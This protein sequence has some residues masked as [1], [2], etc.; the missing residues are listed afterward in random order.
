MPCTRKLSVKAA[1]KKKISSEKGLGLP[2]CVCRWRCLIQCQL[3][4]QQSR[5]LID[6]E[7]PHSHSPFSSLK[8][9]THWSR[10]SFSISCWN[11]WHRSWFEIIHT[12]WA[13]YRI[14]RWR[15]CSKAHPA[16]RGRLRKRGLLN[17]CTSLFVKLSGPLYRKEEC[18][19]PFVVFTET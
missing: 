18:Q 2:E 4:L 14:R 8:H 5:I 17:W 11:Y 7:L 6:N 10:V 1:S 16:E 13:K 15:P 9:I 3:L 19:N 12:L